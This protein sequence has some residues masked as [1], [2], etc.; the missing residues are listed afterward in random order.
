MELDRFVN[1]ERGLTV[2]E[3]S[4]DYLDE[5]LAE[6]SALQRAAGYDPDEFLLP[7]LSRAQIVDAWAARGVQ[8]PEEAIRLW[9]WHNG[10]PPGRY[11]GTSQDSLEKALGAY[12][13]EEKGH[14]EFL[15]NP[16][17]ITV[18]GEGRYAMG[19]TSEPPL[20]RSSDA[21][22]YPST[23]DPNRGTVSFCTIV[24]IGIYARERGFYQPNEAG[25]PSA[26]NAPWPTELQVTELLLW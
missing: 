12:D 21:V 11:P 13:F 25:L 16:D 23:W 19:T 24:A 22:L 26:V 17:Y 6:F 3:A 5:L 18:G 1:T 15:W 9:Q 7:G 10:Y 8:V 2:R 4:P 20:I 14:E